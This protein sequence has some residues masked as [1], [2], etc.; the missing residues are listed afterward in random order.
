MR[1]RSIASQKSHK[2]TKILRH[3]QEKTQKSSI[4]LHFWPFWRSC[5]GLMGEKARIWKR[6]M[7]R[8]RVSAGIYGSGVWREGDFNLAGTSASTRPE[9]ETLAH[10][11]REHRTLVGKIICLLIADKV[12]CLYPKGQAKVREFR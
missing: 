12:L 1:F 8:E 3:V 6:R 10:K 9:D 4:F 5:E 7:A 11:N 2:V